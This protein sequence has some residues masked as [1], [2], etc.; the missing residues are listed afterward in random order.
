MEQLTLDDII[1]FINGDIICQGEKNPGINNISTDSRTIKEDEL[2]IPLIGDHFDGHDYINNVMNK[3]IKAIITDQK[4]WQKRTP[5]AIA[6]KEQAGTG[7][8]GVWIIGVEDTLKAY[9]DIA[10][11][12]IKRLNVIKIGI[13]GS[14]GKTTTKELIRSLI[15]THYNVIANEGNFNNQIGVPKTV[16]TIESEH[17]IA[18]IE[19]GSGKKGDIDCLAKIVEP[20]IG[21]ITTIGAAHT[22]FL[23]GIDGVAEEKKGMLRGFHPLSVAIL[24]R[25]EPYFDFLT[26]GLEDRV[27]SFSIKKDAPFDVIE[28]LGLDGYLI[29][30]QGSQCR[31]QLGGEYN[32]V[33]LGFAVTIADLLKIPKEKIITAIE[34]IKPAKMRSETV[35]GKYTLIKDCYN[36]NPSSMKAGL[37]FLSSIQISGQKIAVLGDML[38]L[39]PESPNHH[40][41]VGVYLTGLNIDYLLTLGNM[42]EKI[43]EGAKK[44]GYSAEKIFSFSDH[45]TLLGQLNNLIKENDLLYFKASRGM[46]LEKITIELEKLN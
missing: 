32:L 21:V 27:C 25:D 45:Q 5:D 36:A 29:N 7:S 35:K 14:N 31:F 24:N 22:E 23:G 37:D 46:E 34:S 4:S 10:K 28:N 2:F 33:N 42:G 41:D 13:T 20:D 6:N 19:M 15:S 17:E 9:Q 3:G 44:N 43:A 16:F 11:H 18:L 12:Y 26:A 40:E 1:W 39:G 8:S 30:Y 38:E